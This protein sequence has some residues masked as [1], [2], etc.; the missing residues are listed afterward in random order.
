[1]NQA[2][3]GL[4][5]SLAAA[6]AWSQQIP[7]YPPNPTGP[8]EFAADNPEGLVFAGVRTDGRHAWKRKV[9]WRSS[10]GTPAPSSPLVPRA[11]AAELQAMARTLDALVAV[12][13]ATP[14][15]S[16]GEGFWVND[17]RQVGFVDLHRAPPGAPPARWPMEFESGLFPFYH[18]DSLQGGQW[19]LSVRGE[20][21]S[22]YFSFNRLPGGLRQGPI[23]QE[24]ASGPDRVPVELFLRPRVTDT[25]FGLPVYERDLLVIAR[26]GRDPWA[27]VALGRALRATLPLF[28]QDRETAERRLA[29]L[30]AENDK[31]QAPA[32][33]QAQRDEFEKNNGALRQTRPSNYAVRFANME[34]YIGVVRAEAAAKANPQRDATGAWYWNAIDAHEAATRQ[35]AALTPAQ[36]AAPACWVEAPNQPAANG[37]KPSEGRYA[38]KGELVAVGSVPGC[39]ELVETNPAYFDLNLPRTAPQIMSFG[40]GRCNLGLR[41]GLLIVPTP[42]RWDAPPQGCHRHRTMW[43]EADWKAIAALVVP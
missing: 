15:G 20:T 36:A 41:D 7:R 2:F 43:N 26:A 10:T 32:W 40:F 27:P 13:K 5:F 30:R 16:Q 37:M 9:H 23:A 34:R 22:T 6:C 1:M 11:S 4:V 38:M 29:S 28:Q 18:E 42:S 17:A 8:P 39:R 31:V 35:A 3:A 33:E 19:R 25:F 12:F 21:E 14:T 24:P